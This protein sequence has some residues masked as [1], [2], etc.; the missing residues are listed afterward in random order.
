MYVWRTAPSAQLFVMLEEREKRRLRTNR[1]HNP[2]AIA[3]F[4]NHSPIPNVMAV[5]FDIDLRYVPPDWQPW[6]PTLLF[7][8]HPLQP[9]LLPLLLFVSLRTIHPEEEIFLDYQFAFDSSNKS[10]IFP[11]WYTS[12]KRIDNK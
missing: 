5:S 12:T 6:L 4:V 9:H 11:S 7:R 2:W 3:H 1:Y 8:P 10:K